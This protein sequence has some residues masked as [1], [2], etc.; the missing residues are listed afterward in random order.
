M[1]IGSWRGRTVK[2]LQTVVDIVEHWLVGLLPIKRVIQEF[3]NK[4]THREFVHIKR[5]RRIRI[6]DRCLPYLLQLHLR[7][8][9][10]FYREHGKRLEKL[11]ANLRLCRLG[12]SDDKRHPPVGTGEHIYNHLGITIF[13]VV[14]NYCRCLRKH[15]IKVDNWCKDR[16]FFAKN[17]RNRVHFSKKISKTCIFSWKNFVK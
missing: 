11:L 6:K 13:D 5:Q 1:E 15:S 14:Q 4:H 7:P 8:I 12:H 10:I 17:I 9:V 2:P 16:H 3:G